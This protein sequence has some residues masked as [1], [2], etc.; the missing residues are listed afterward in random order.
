MTQSKFTYERAIREVVLRKPESH[1]EQSM[2][3]C[4]LV[5]NRWRGPIHRRLFEERLV[6]TLRYLGEINEISDQLETGFWFEADIGNTVQLYDLYSLK[7]HDLMPYKDIAITVRCFYE[8]EVAVAPRPDDPP[9]KALLEP[10]IQQ[11]FSCDAADFPD[12]FAHMNE[13][14]ERMKTLCRNLELDSEGKPFFTKIFE[15]V[16]QSG[17]KRVEKHELKAALEMLEMES[18]DQAVEHIFKL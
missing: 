5:L 3:L 14:Y 17:N 6:T 11:L 8:V 9:D 4:R 18:S 13:A 1:V 16:D 12:V 15:G 10:R 2:R 7:L